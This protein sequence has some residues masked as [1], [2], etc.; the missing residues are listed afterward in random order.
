MS[1][2][3]RNGSDGPALKL[4]EFLCFAVYSASHAFNRVYK[5]LLDE[6]EIT[7]PQYLVMVLLWERDDQTVGDL[8]EKLFLESNTL[9]PLLKRLEALGYVNRRRDPVDERQVRVGLTDKGRAL[10][11][12]AQRIPSCILTASGL[13]ADKAEQL[14]NG[15]AALRDS[16]KSY[17]PE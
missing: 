16:L 5:P 3:A 10:R 9:T 15:I 2:D 6:L 12:K 17:S 4:E 8:G 1:S 11:A 7:Y 13:D 14:L